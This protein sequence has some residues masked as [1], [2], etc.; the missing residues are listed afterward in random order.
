MRILVLVI[1]SH[2][3]PE[4][5]QMEQLWL[6]TAPSRAPSVP[7]SRQVPSWCDVWLVHS[8]PV[9]QWIGDLVNDS[10]VDPKNV[11]V[12]I[13]RRTIY[14]K[15]DEC[16][17]PGILAKT[18]K[19]L[20]FLS[21]FN[22]YDFVWRTNLSSVLDFHGLLEYCKGIPS[23]GVYGGYIGQYQHS[24]TKKEGVLKEGARGVSASLR[25]GRENH[26]FSRFA[27][28]AGFLMSA[29]V[30]EYLVLNQALL[31]WDLIDD[32]AIG[33][34]LEPVFG[35]VHIERQWIQSLDS[36][37]ISSVFHYRCESYMHYNTVAYMQLVI[38]SLLSQNT[39]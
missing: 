5:L 12:D 24:D 3:K 16:L 23:S 20:Q 18:I 26:G 14:I 21:K 27:S 35:L 17:I 29:D 10:D 33:I 19:A 11:E 37:V 9:G 6:A 13:S 4:Y 2:N 1:A 32:V 39:V 25:E 34:L 8:K 7:L 15:Q 30:V 38:N 22:K 31:R 36:D 28:G